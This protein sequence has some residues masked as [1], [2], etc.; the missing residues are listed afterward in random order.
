MVRNAA[1]T[2]LNGV[3]LDRHRRIPTAER[4]GVPFMLARTGVGTDHRL[5]PSRRP[6]RTVQI[7]RARLFDGPKVDE[8]PIS[9]MSRLVGSRLVDINTACRADEA[10]TRPVR[11]PSPRA[12]ACDRAEAGRI[13]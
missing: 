7:F 10:P 2:N 6:L 11:P 12:S 3:G 1:M 5:A 13:R 8:V 4:P 9:L